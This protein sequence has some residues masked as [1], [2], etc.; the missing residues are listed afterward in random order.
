MPPATEWFANIDNE[1]TCRAYCNDLQE[2]MR[3]VV[4][5]APEELRLVTRAHILPWRS[6]TSSAAN[7]PA[8]RSAARSPPSPP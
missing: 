5:S 7:S 8:A 3:F 6:K 4:I 2:F 1:N